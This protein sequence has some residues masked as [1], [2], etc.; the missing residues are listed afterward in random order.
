MAVAQGLLILE[1]Q[2]PISLLLT[3]RFPCLQGLAPTCCQVSG[4]PI[5]SLPHI[6]S[7]T[8]EVSSDLSVARRV[9]KGKEKRLA[10]VSLL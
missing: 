2:S 4:P 5:V 10:N 9:G 7:A 8:T 6:Q 3:S 1:G